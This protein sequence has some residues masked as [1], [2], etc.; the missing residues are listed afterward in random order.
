MKTS[1]SKIAKGGNPLARLRTGE[2]DPDPHFRAVLRAKLVTAA[3]S[4]APTAPP[5]TAP[6]PVAGA[7]ARA[8]AGQVMRS[9]DS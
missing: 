7:P 9:R 1:R 5:H 8:E 6:A 4:A 3:A 2:P